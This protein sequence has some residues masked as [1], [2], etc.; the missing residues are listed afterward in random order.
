MADLNS[1]FLPD[2]VFEK[3]LISMQC[4]FIQENNGIGTKLWKSEIAVI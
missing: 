1:F 2:Q 4:K 3:D